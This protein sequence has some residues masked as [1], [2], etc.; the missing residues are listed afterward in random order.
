MPLPGARPHIP[1]LVLSDKLRSQLEKWSKKGMSPSAINTMVSCER[2]FAY[3]YLLKLQEQKDIQESMESN[4]IG[5][6]VH[7]VFEEGLKKEIDSILNPEHLNS[8]LDNLDELLEKATTK[9]YNT[10]IAK[11]GENLLLIESARSTIKKLINKELNEMKAPD[12]EELE[13]LGIESKLTAEYKLANGKTVTLF[14]LAD[15]VEKA[16]DNTRVVDYKTGNTTDS[17]LKLKADFKDELSTGKKNKAIQ[18]L[19]YCAMLLKDKN[20]GE[21]LDFVSAGIRSGQNAKAGLLELKIDKSNK[22]TR[23]SVAQL[24]EWIQERLEFLEDPGQELEHKDDSNFCQYCV[25]LDPKKN[26]W[27]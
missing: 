27:S 10:S 17:D 19:V 22:I 23:D 12:A 16:N 14:G 25:V 4:T 26:F 21:H 1:P 13:L 24:I 9:Y 2:N 5:S 6:I 18:L 7:F 15:K 20:L 3:R 11:K 8:I